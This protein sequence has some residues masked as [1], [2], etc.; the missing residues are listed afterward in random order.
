MS[1]PMHRLQISL[2]RSQVRYLADRARREGISI[3]EVLR[4]LVRREAE[5]KSPRAVESYREIIGIGQE[6]EPLIDNIPVSA[7]PDL[8]IAEQAAPDFAAC[9][10]AQTGRGILIR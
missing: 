3:A 2:P 5:T 10:K 1:M 8:Y 4:R 9:R 7:Q 6:R